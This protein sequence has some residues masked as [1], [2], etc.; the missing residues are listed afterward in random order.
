[1]V[2]KTSK[3]AKETYYVLSLNGNWR[4]WVVNLY[5]EGLPNLTIESNTIINLIEIDLMLLS[6]Y[7]YFR[8]LFITLGLL[9]KEYRFLSS[10]K[11]WRISLL[12]NKNRRQASQSKRKICVLKVERSNPITEYSMLAYPLVL[13]FNWSKKSPTISARGNS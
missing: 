6:K 4:S 10:Q 8:Y 11:S 3:R 7:I 2:R 13:D 5:K 9:W 1:M 12:I